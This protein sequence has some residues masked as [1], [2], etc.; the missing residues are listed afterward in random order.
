MLERMSNKSDVTDSCSGEEFSPF[1]WKILNNFKRK[2]YCVEAG[3]LLFFPG[4][5]SY[6]RAATLI[7]W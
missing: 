5:L 3:K 4:Y 6:N 2:H 1:F 7:K